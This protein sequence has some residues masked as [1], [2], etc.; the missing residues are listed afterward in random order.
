ME[1]HYLQHHRKS[2]PKQWQLQDESNSGQSASAT[3]DG[4]AA[5]RCN[6]VQ[7]WDG[8]VAVG[9]S[10]PEEEDSGCSTS[11][12]D[13]SDAF[14]PLAPSPP[15]V[16]AAAPWPIGASGRAP[17]ACCCDDFGAELWLLG[18]LLAAPPAPVT[19]E[20]GP[21]SIG[22]GCWWAMPPPEPLANLARTR[23]SGGTFEAAVIGLVLPLGVIDGGVG[24]FNDERRGAHHDT[25][26]VH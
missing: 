12:L 2:Q 5:T 6:N 20:A 16:A 17:E 10:A 11:I 9:C 23:A 22:G 15:L 24:P 4:K 7:D 1:S 26:R 19:N 18:A 3:G 14:L 21:A 8:V 13:S 25:N